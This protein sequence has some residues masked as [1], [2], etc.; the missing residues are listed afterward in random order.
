MPETVEPYAEI[1]A[2]DLGVGEAQIAEKVLEVKTP[3]T[4]VKST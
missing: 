2:L 4:P 3:P 1:Q